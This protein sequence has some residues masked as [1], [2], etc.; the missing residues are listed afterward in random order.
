MARARTCVHV[1][2]C[3]TVYRWGSEGSSAES[4]LVFYLYRGGF[5]GSDSIGGEHLDGLP[6]LTFTVPPLFSLI[7]PPPSSL[8]PS[9]TPFLFPNKTNWVVSLVPITP[10]PERFET[11]V[12]MVGN[13][14]DGE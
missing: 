2:T 7:F 6:C 13:W 14:G 1:C 5:A 8:Q 4:V 12:G 10:G 3:A 9:T 11:G